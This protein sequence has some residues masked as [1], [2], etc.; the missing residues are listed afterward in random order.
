MA[1]TKPLMPAG[2]R[3]GMNAH[4]SRVRCPRDLPRFGDCKLRYRALEEHFG[5]HSNL[6]SSVVI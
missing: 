1:E 6:D 2:L 5:I 3:H 4:D